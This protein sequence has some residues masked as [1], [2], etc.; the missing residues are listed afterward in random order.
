MRPLIRLRWPSLWAYPVSHVLLGLIVT[1]C[2]EGLGEAPDSRFPVISGSADA[3]V[4]ESVRPRWIDH[5]GWTLSRRP[6]LSIGGQ[7][8]VIDEDGD[9]VL[10]G[11]IRSL[12]VLESGRMAVAD[13]QS[14]VVSVFDSGGELTHRFGGRGEGPGEFRAIWDLF[15]C[16]NDTVIVQHGP[17]LNVFG[18]DGE[19]VRRFTS[20][21]AG[22]VWGLRVVH[23]DCHEFI[24]DRRVDGGTPPP[25]QDWLLRR[26]L[27][28]TDHSFLDVDTI[29]IEVDGEMYTGFLEG[30]EVPAVLPWTPVTVNV[31]F[32]GDEV[33]V[34]FGR[35][36]ELRVYA[37]QTGLHQLFRWHA[38]P[39]PI[40][41]A[42]HERYSAKRSAFL[43]RRGDNPYTRFSFPAL[44]ELPR[45]P[46]SRPVFDGFLIDDRCNIWVRHFPKTALGIQDQLPPVDPPPVETW[47][48]LDSAGIWLGPI[49]LPERFAAHDVANGRVY[50][51]HTAA[52]G[53]ETVRVYR[54]DGAEGASGSC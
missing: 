7:N 48:V 20:S 16:A 32:R 30:E 46:T 47:T 1:G 5:P 22:V 42:D 11:S 4:V 2:S 38:T 27:V 49:R 14:V 40:A 52:E 34:G 28:R 8:P 3:E 13:E 26:V 9:T 35:L 15:D 53:I 31:H 54:I 45:I 39:D 24:A 21:G 37:L 18:G 33:V 50:G 23:P 17:E 6:D 12:N 44:R 25:G 43:A 36:A 10:F 29:A 41:A 51:V 19:F